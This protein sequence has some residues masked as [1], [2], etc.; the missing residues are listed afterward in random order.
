M[1]QETQNFRT[2]T[3]L[4]PTNS[5]IRSCVNCGKD[6]TSSLFTFTR[7]FLIGVRNY[8]PEK[9]D[10]MGW[11]NATTSTIVK[12]NHCGCNYIRDVFVADE[13]KFSQPFSEKELEV[14]L[15]SYRSSFRR[16]NIERLQNAN[17]IIDKLLHFALNKTSQELSFLD[18]G[19]SFGYLGLVARARGF[20]CVKAY[21]SKFR[22]N[23]SGILSRHH[24]IDIEL[25]RTK[26]DLFKYAPFDVITCQTADEHFFDLQGEIKLMRELLSD[27]GILYMSH[28][29]MD[30][31]ADIHDLKREQTINEK[32][33]LLLRKSYHPDHLNYVMPNMFREM[34]KR[35]GFKE[36]RVFLSWC[37]LEVSILNWRNVRRF[38]REIV[39]FVLDVLGIKYRKTIF[40]IEKI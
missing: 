13:E 8:P 14:S 5:I 21:D 29:V 10:E 26:E 38:I 35:N 33:K 4:D 24:A 6:E 22:P 25:L 34:L 36:K 19:A 17:K 20:N 40:F 15:R 39:K 37:D 2:L 7:D 18:F 16:A 31:D 1:T 30:L 11:T 23:V 32:A 28:P 12:C 9:L 3:P 27:S